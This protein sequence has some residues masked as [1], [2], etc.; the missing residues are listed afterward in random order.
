MNE[1]LL[2]RQLDALSQELQAVAPPESVA[3]AIGAAAR[4]SR[5]LSSIR[6]ARTN[7]RER[8]LAWPLVIAA[9][10]AVIAWTLHAQRSEQSGVSPEKTNAPLAT[11]FIPLVPVGEIVR[12]EGA[13]VVST[14][15][16]RMM[17]AEF[18]LPVDPA[19]AADSVSSELLVRRDGTVLA[20]RFID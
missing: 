4:S 13:Y 9:A 18:G 12:D 14:P 3:R 2:D 1:D 5:S 10:V 15:M 8:W 17:L 19:R 6:P 20:V 11:E 7:G 16:P